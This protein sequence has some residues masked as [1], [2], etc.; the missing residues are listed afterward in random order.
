MAEALELLLPDFGGRDFGPQFDNMGDIFHSQLGIALQQQGIQFR[1]P[2]E[3]FAF[4]RGNL[5]IIR[6]HALL[7]ALFFQ[8]GTLF[9]KVL[10][11]PLKLHPPGDIRILQVQVGAGLVDEV[12]GLV[13]Q[14]T[15]CDVPLAQQHSLPQNTVGDLNSVIGFIVGGQTL[16]NFDGIL[17]G[18]FVH[19]HRLEAALQCAVLF[20]GFPIF[21]ES[22]RADD[23][24]FAAAEGGLQD[25]GGIHAAL[26]IPGSY[27]IVDLIDHQDDIAQL[28]HL[29]DKALHPLLELAAELGAGYQS[30]QIQQIDFLIPQL[31]RYVPRHDPLS[32]PLGDG[33]LA[34]AR[35]AD[36][37]GIVLLAA[38]QDLNDPLDLLGAANHR[39]Q[40]ALLGLAVQGDAVAL[41]KLPLPV[42]LALFL[43]PAFTLTGRGVLL[44]GR[45]SVVVEQ[46]VQEREGRRLA[47]LL[48]VLS[49]GQILH[50]FNG[51]HGLH[52]LVI[53]VIQILIRDA[54]ALHHVV[55]LR[56]PKALGA[57]QAQALVDG[58]VPLH[59]GDENR[60][61]IL[62]TSGT[63]CWLHNYLRIPRFAER[64]KCL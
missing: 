61:N 49:A 4:Q 46:A 2:L 28:L 40:L 18:R 29:V 60:G 21:V 14:E 35:F 42:G 41:Q 13:R 26:G 45:L 59:A 32:Q 39:I 54:H 34:D 20:D 5:L 33:G 30:R 64:G 12:D 8:H 1:L 55:H 58:L 50:I 43:L 48:I 10:D 24:N 15:V 16:E 56:K 6:L 63:K 36:E 37:A 7:S 17:N 3:N 38:V 22:G 27:D 9:F 52:H 25:I 47:G 31:E 19:R 51:V 23:L 11:L 53:Q 44:G 57:F 62:F